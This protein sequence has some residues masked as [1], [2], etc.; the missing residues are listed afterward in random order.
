MRDLLWQA[1]ALASITTFTAIGL[2]LRRAVARMDH[3]RDQRRAR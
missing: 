1:T 3:R 2:Y